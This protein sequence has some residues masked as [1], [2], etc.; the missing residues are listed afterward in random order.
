MQGELVKYIDYHVFMTRLATHETTQ[1]ALISQLM[2]S[3]KAS[4]CRQ[5]F[6]TLS[7]FLSSRLN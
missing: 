6:R 2:G 4:H 3:Q 1:L 7:G 5:P